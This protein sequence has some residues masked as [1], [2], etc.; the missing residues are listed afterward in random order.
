MFREHFAWWG[1]SGLVY[2]FPNV[3]IAGDWMPEF[4]WIFFLYSHPQKAYSSKRGKNKKQKKM[5]FPLSTETCDEILHNVKCVKWCAKQTNG[6]QT[7]YFSQNPNDVWMSI[8]FQRLLCT[9]IERPIGAI[10]WEQYEVTERQRENSVVQ[11][12]MIP[13][14]KSDLFK[15]KL[16]G[17]YEIDVYQS[18]RHKR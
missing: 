3:K 10:A 9:Q 14:R 13:F 17:L 18:A 1:H 16:N 2:P 7:R 15:S 4:D 6:Q 8:Y 5:R 11:N 12:L